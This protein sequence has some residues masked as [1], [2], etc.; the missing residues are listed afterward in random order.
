[1]VLHF[2]QALS[3]SQRRLVIIALDLML[4]PIALAFC[5]AVQVLPLSATEFASVLIPVLPY[6]LIAALAASYWFE[7]PQVRPKNFEGRALLRFAAYA[8]TCAVAFVGIGFVWGLPF[9]VSTYLLFGLTYFALGTMARFA[10]RGILVELYRR[11]VPQKRVL[12]YGA[13]TTGTE[14]V[15]ALRSHG[16][17]EPVALIDDNASLHGMIISGVPVYSPAQIKTL[18]KERNIERALIAIP[19]ISPPKQ[20]QIARR[21]Q[22]M[23]MDVQVLPSFSQLIGEEELIDKF[24]SLPGKSFLGRSEVEAVLGENAECYRGK[25]V[26]ISGSGGSI[27]SE[28]C[29][30]VLE[31]APSRL[32]LFELSEFAL[33]TVD[34]EMRQLLESSEHFR[35]VEIVPI[36]GSVTDPRLVRRVLSEQDVDVVLHA[37]AYK[38]VPLVEA[39]PLVGLGNNIFG[40]QTL[41]RESFEAG[42]ERFILVSSDKAVRPVNVMGASKRMAELIVQ[43]L[44]SRVPSGGGPRYSMVRFGNVLG[45]SGS[46]VPLFQDQIRRGG[47]V[48]VTH[49]AV[50]RYFMTVQEAAQLVLTAGAMAQGGEVYVLDMGKPVPITKLARQTIQASGYTVRDEDDPDGDIEIKIVGLRP[51]EKMEEEL[52]ITSEHEF[53]RHRKIFSA[54]EESLSEIEVARTLRALRE[55]IAGQDERAA[56]AAI[57]AAIKE[58]TPAQD[59]DGV[60]A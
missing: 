30:Q 53:T 45:S 27:G 3:R 2:I 8:G 60:R 58:Y 50:T 33:Y 12:I 5:F 34:M 35:D 11:G 15:S 4:I 1:M 54:Q 52:T 39:N 59:R 21:M 26:L 23:G 32:V 7:L 19:S 37:A 16:S 51:G 17:I 13:G 43:D 49:E 29:R 22:A 28:L 40:T 55:A 31:C 38:H 9:P 24:V 44:A 10:T 41:A 56:R 18:V 36:L 46:V 14:L 42:I 20:A 48:T 57:E 47:P 25:S 6:F